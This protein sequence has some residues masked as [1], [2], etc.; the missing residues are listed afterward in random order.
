MLENFVHITS[1]T[2]EAAG[3]I[4]IAFGALVSTILAFTQYIRHKAAHAAY[5][6]LR[7]RLS[8]GILLGLEFLIAA[9][10]IRTV[11][12]EPS[13]HSLGLLA[14]IVLIRTFLSFTLQLEVSGKWPWEHKTE[15]NAP[16]LAAKGK[17]RKE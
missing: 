6:G 15:E 16:A 1:A 3:I 4:A 14:I 17:I 11:A 10:I 8:R 2:L 13:F 9:D 12:V 5:Q 7:R